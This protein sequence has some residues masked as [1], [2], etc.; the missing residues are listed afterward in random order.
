MQV[1]VLVRPAR[2]LEEWAQ[3]PMSLWAPL[4]LVTVSAAQTMVAL[5]M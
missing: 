5:V 3:L 4:D 1:V 2:L